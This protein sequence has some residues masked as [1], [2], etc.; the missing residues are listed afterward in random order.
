MCRIRINIKTHKPTVGYYVGVC[1]KKGF[2]YI[3]KNVSMGTSL[4]YQW[5]PA[6]E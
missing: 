2:Y 4:L 5:V 6:Q 1:T 3:S